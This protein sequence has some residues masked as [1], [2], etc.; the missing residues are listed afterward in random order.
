M[1]ATY[2][3]IL[4]VLLLGQACRTIKKQTQAT[5]QEL[6]LESETSYWLYQAYDSTAKRWQYQ[7]DSPFYYH[8]DKGLYG[9]GGR[10]TMAESGLQLSQW[11]QH[12]SLALYRMQ[13]QVQAENS[14][15]PPKRSR[16]NYW[17]MTVLLVL[18]L[19]LIAGR[20]YFRRISNRKA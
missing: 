16:Y 9:Y 10:L 11:Q 12:D 18:L 6:N 2:L 15:E 20:F 7:S 3:L 14:S 13:Q 5:Q 17:T 8:P 4:I 1:R 19:A